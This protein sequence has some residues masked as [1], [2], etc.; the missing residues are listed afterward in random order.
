M[1]PPYRPTSWFAIPTPQVDGA[2]QAQAAQVPL[3]TSPHSTTSRRSRARVAATYRSN[4]RRS[5]DWPS[6]IMATALNSSP[7]I[8]RMEPMRGRR[9]VPLFA[10]TGPCQ[11]ERRVQVTEPCR[12]ERRSKRRNGG[13]RHI[14]NDFGF[15][16]DHGCRA[17]RVR[18]QA[19]DHAELGLQPGAEV[20]VPMSAV[21]QQRTFGMLPHENIR[22]SS[23]R[24]CRMVSTAAPMKSTLDWTCSA[25]G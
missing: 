5:S 22:R 17:P 15:R 1:P 8:W 7:L 13:R 23:R 21:R 11:G 6:M 24:C 16:L 14:R 9:L 19:L 10:R 3:G 12:G 25:I 4:S 20:T 18:R 2:I